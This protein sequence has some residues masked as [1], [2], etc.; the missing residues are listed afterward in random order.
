MA[1]EEAMV[2][3]GSMFETTWQ[4]RPVYDVGRPH[5]FSRV[6]RPSIHYYTTTSS[7]KRQTPDCCL[8][9]RTGHPE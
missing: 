6:S 3:G 9:G 2:K 7:W 5:R 1:E 8:L 4:E